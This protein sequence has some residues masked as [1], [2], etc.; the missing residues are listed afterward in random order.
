MKKDNTRHIHVKSC[1]RPNQFLAFKSLCEES[2]VSI[3]RILSD[4]A[5]YWMAWMNYAKEQS[6][7]E[8]PEVAQI[9]AMFPAFRGGT[10]FPEL[11]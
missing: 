5:D 1:F 7:T 3:S 10:P 6:E 11:I 9:M 2:D 8:G 4:L